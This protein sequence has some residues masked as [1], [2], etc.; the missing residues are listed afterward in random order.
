MSRQDVFL[1]KI[2][3]YGTAASILSVTGTA[4][5]CFLYR[6]QNAYSAEWHRLNPTAATCLGTGKI[7][8]ITEKIEVK[9]F[10][11]SPAAVHST[12][13][14]VIKNEIG[15]TS[16]TDLIMVGTLN[17]TAG[18]FLDMTTFVEWEDPL[19]Y[20]GN[21]Y[22]IRKVYNLDI[23]NNIGQMILLKRSA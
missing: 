5:P 23:T 20:D 16:N 15:E 9:A 3:R 11:Y 18:G 6:G 4:C 17:T 21:K 14:D 7:N 22:R 12:L 8:R 19:T 1:G 2:K 10:F 13:P